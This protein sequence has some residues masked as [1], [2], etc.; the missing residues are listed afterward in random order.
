LAHD[1]IRVSTTNDRRRTTNT[2]STRSRLILVLGALALVPAYWLPLWSI[3]IVAPQYRE[4]L[5]MFI[6]LRDI[7]G[8]RPHDI[9]NINILNHYIGMQEI[10]P[11]VVDVLTIMP[12]VVGFLIVTAIVVA[13]LGRRWMVFAWLVTFAALG[14]AGLYEFWSWNY[15]YGHNLSP[16]APIKIPGMSYQPPI[17]GTKQL[18]NMTTSSYPSWG[19]LFI[20]LSF[21]AGALSL[22]VSRKQGPQGARSPASERGRSRAGLASATAVLVLVLGIPACIPA[23]GSAGEHSSA[24]EVSIAGFACDYCDG[25]IPEARFGGTLTT[26]DG[27]TYR[28]MSVECLAGFIGSGSVAEDR[29]EAVMVVDYNHGEALIDATEARYVRMQWEQSPNGLNLAAVPTERLAANLHYFLGG[30]RMT[31][32]E[33]LDYVK[34]EWDL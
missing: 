12:W 17:F 8:H 21:A 18:L 10:D 13:I 25:L 5:G 7:W 22:F 33:V 4:G 24:E 34:R 23:P 3:R 19:T 30:E 20:A 11:A 26:S 2:M 15:D 1:D 6:G 9:Q 27:N 28:F 14:T 29:I 16:M 32:P 31:W